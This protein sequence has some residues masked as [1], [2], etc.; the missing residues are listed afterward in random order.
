VS[1]DG[2][3]AT[4][5]QSA[6][7][8]AWRVWIGRALPV[9]GVFVSAAALLDPR[10][11][12]GIWLGPLVAGAGL[13]L[14]AGARSARSLAAARFAFA[15]ALGFAA[16]ALAAPEFRADAPEF[17]V[18][19]PSLV[20]DHDLSLH[21]DWLEMGFE[22]S[23]PA[24]PLG[25]TRNRHAIGPALVWSPFYA[26]AHV[27]TLADGAWGSGRYAAD[28]H[29]LPY[30]RAAALGTITAALAG[31]WLLAHTLARRFGR[32]VAWLAVGG[33]LAASPLLYYVFA[34]PYMSHGVTFGVAAALVWAAE[35]ARRRPSTVGWVA[36]GALFGLLVV[37]RWQAAVYGLLVAP[38]MLDGLRR[39]TL[40]LGTALAATAAAIAAFSPQ[41]LV[42]R[43]LFG[44]ALTMP[45]GGGFIDWT[46]P[47]WLDTLASADHGLFTWTP[48]L[49]LGLVGLVAG[50]RRAAWLHAPALLIL[51]AT[52]WTNGGADD[53]AGS[54]A[55]GAR[56]FDLVIPL[57]AVGLAVAIEALRR[58]VARRPLAA[59]AAL[60]A[61]FALWN[62]GFVAL[63]REHRY[64][65]PLRV[66]RLAAD[67]ARLAR[68]GAEDAL[69]ALFG[70]RGRA[71]AHKL[72]AAD[73]LYT[74]ARPGGRI[75]LPRAEEGDLAGRW[76]PAR[77]LGDG[78]AFRWA[79]PPEACLLVPIEEPYELRATLTWRPS[80]V[81]RDVQVRANTTTIGAFR[82]DG[83]WQ[84]TELLL[85]R[86][87]L[88][89]GPN[90][91]CLV[92]PRL[93][94]DGDDEPFAAV[95]AFEGA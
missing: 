19:L 80:R 65:G 8:T 62:L 79:Y 23:P 12:A 24:T 89:P 66:E 56:R 10:R 20:F 90:W 85:P 52:T 38:V 81:A 72:F 4:E 26:L 7:R 30:R 67:Q 74:P 36:L 29:A 43:T 49:L 46:S 39:G 91:L 2:N 17:F 34:A 92:S 27:Y 45:Q 82:L 44:R 77:R 15:L 59:P 63:Y 71:F 57:L 33:A 86:R 28:G 58:Q 47:R 94:D 75:A 54:E 35:R 18:Y 51:A 3:G 68:G 22:G 40:R 11:P 21:D 88:V 95:A 78:P 14:G 41:M 1:G 69:F 5:A 76:S 83:A 84:K 53:W 37:V 55:F 6:Q 50:V 32:G 70:P 64:E 16:G 60:V 61:L 42:W 31:A 73:Y 9:V 87:T 48:L 93:P 13:A 25:L